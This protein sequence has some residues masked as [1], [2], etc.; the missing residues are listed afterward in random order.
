MLGNRP[1]WGACARADRLR[2]G[3]AVRRLSGVA[4]PELS[5]GWRVEGL[6]LKVARYVFIFLYLKI[7][8]VAGQLVAWCECTF[9]FFWP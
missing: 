9:S 1:P 7:Q 3:L 5:K 8:V 2:R 6:T 4:C